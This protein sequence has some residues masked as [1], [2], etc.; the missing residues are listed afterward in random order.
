MP[1]NPCMAFA[2]SSRL[3]KPDLCLSPALSSLLIQAE[4]I[5][6]LER[7]P[8]CVAD[9]D[10]LLGI[11]RNLRR[12][13]WWWSHSRRALKPR[14]QLPKA[15]DYARSSRF[16]IVYGRAFLPC[17]SSRFLGCPPLALSERLHHAVDLGAQFRGRWHEG[18]TERILVDPAF[19]LKQRPLADA[20]KRLHVRAFHEPE[21]ARSPASVNR[22]ESGKHGQLLSVAGRPGYIRADCR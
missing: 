22:K 14:D 13:P 19:R 10:R 7:S 12:W 2:S 11:I 18:M 5:F 9:L 16:V 8:Q 1:E 17:V 6:C 4:M 3:P 15:F 20:F 21:I